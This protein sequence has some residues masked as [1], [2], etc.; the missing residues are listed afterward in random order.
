MNSNNKAVFLTGA[1]SGLGE[2]TAERLAADGYDLALVDLNE[3]GVTEIAERVAMT[4]VR[5]WSAGLDVSNQQQV[6]DAFA[7]AIA[8]HG[9]IWA[10][11]NA[12]GI[13]RPSHF[14][15]VTPAD[16]ERTFAVNVTGT[17]N[18]CQAA[19]AHFTDTGAGG[20]IVNVSS[21]AAFV[22]NPY[23]IAYASSKGAV[24][25]LTRS[26][27]RALAPRNI[28]VNAVAPGLIRTPMW[29]EGGQ[30]IADNA[31][32][33]PGGVARFQGVTSEQAFDNACN[34]IPLGRPQDASDVAAAIAH[35]ISQDTRN[36]TGQILNIDGG[37]LMR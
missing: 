1:A 28:N 25:T 22:G 32:S 14:E 35:L 9:S 17:F 20:R 34:A 8:F 31:E 27:A 18:V 12:A 37:L 30:W 3:A 24:D 5:V 29:V 21:I 16:F 15:E 4:G 23:T 11:A 2:A 6:A 7:E 13:A 26:L 10:V 36:V 33:G 19:A